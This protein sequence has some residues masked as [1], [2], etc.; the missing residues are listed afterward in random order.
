ML[1]VSFWHLHHSL[2]A[3]CTFCWASHCSTERS[4]LQGC[5][6]VQER[7]CLHVASFTSGSV[8]PRACRACRNAALEAKLLDCGLQENRARDRASRGCSR[9]LGGGPQRGR[10]GR[11]RGDRALT[12]KPLSWRRPA[13]PARS[14]H[15]GSGRCQM[16][17]QSPRTP[18]PRL[19]AR[20][21]GTRASRHPGPAEDKHITA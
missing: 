8:V 14:R 1:F 9:G 6:M 16:R 2:Q 4:K 10:K 7:A 17:A 11:E 3:C 13:H 15:S 5:E 19:A 20:L 12:W 18:T 21:R